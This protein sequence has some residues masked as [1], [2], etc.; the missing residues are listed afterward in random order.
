M[1]MNINNYLENKQIFAVI[2]LVLLSNTMTMGR[3]LPRGGWISILLTLAAI[4]L[5]GIILR[6]NEQEQDLV[7]ASFS[8]FGKGVGTFFAL[9]LCAAAVISS[10]FSLCQFIDFTKNLSMNDTSVFLI[11]AAMMLS[12]F[13]IRS[14]T[15]LSRW[16]SVVV[17]IVI[18]FLAFSLCMTIP[19]WDL[20]NLLPVSFAPE[21]G[22]V[23]WFCVCF[24]DLF[25]VLAQFS[26]RRGYRSAFS[27]TVWSTLLLALIF[28]RN[29]ALLGYRLS[30]LL[31][32]PAYTASGL[33][34]LGSFFQRGEALIS[35]PFV[36]CDL[37]KISVFILFAKNSLAAVSKKL[38]RKGTAIGLSALVFAAGSVLSQYAISF[39]RVKI[40]VAVVLIAFVLLLAAARLVRAAIRRRPGTAAADSG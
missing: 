24:S 1:V 39:F 34:T 38:D 4:P 36:L 31:P 3:Y 10:V 37:L 18:L 15:E 6:I 28:V 2:F 17:Y 16:S 40:V 23:Y 14:I 25:F 13:F 32:Y 8:V 20:G 30:S 7:R 9:L 29:I 12:V 22:G 26:H 35:V 11:G 27:A 21:P 33:I 5:Y 19:D